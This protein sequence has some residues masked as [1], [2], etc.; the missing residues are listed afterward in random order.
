MVEF[1]VAEVKTD[2]PLAKLRSVN[3][4]IAIDSE[5]FVQMDL[6]IP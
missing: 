4:R 6:A 2:Y 5:G 3:S 1:S